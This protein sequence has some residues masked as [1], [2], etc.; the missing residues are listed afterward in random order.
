MIRDEGY[1]MDV[2]HVLNVSLFSGNV[3]HIWKQV[4]FTLLLKADNVSLPLNELKI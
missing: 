3:S 4:F 2:S 1:G